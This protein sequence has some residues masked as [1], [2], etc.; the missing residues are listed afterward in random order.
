MTENTLNQL[1][2]T[3]VFDLMAQSTKDLSEAKNKNDKTAFILI[4][5]QVEL[6]KRFLVSKRSEYRPG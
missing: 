2:I 4:N 1:P 5:E 6:L 3:T